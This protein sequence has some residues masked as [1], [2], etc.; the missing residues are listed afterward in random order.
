MISDLGVPVAFSI[1]LFYSVTFLIKW[2]TGSLEALILSRFD[3]V[4]LIVIKLI[5]KQ[6]EMEIKLS[7]WSSNT[8]T[9][10]KYIIQLQVAKDEQEK[11]RI[12][13]KYKKDNGG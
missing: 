4:R 6:K 8:E 1:A 7:E 5:D 10:V 3:E 2:I 12:I 13:K 9:L 11:T